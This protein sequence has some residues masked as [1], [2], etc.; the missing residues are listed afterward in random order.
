MLV[1]LFVHPSRHSLPLVLLF[2]F[3][4][5]LCFAPVAQAASSVALVIASRGEVVAVNDQGR[6]VLQRRSGLFEGDRIETGNN[7]QVQIRFIDGALLT[8]EHQTKLEISRFENSTANKS[9]Q[10]L[11]RLIQGGLRNLTG[12]IAEQHPE[13]Y[14]VESAIA[15]IGVRGT[16]FRVVLR[17]DKLAAGV[18]SGGIVVSNDAG[19]L[20][21]GAD[22][23]FSFAWV[24]SPRLPPTGHLTAPLLLDDDSPQLNLLPPR[25]DVAQAI[26]RFNH[27]STLDKLEQQVIRDDDDT[28]NNPPPVSKLPDWV[29]STPLDQRSLISF[30]GIN[31]QGDATRGTIS[32][33]QSNNQSGLQS[34]P[35]AGLVFE[36]SNSGSTSTIDQAFILNGSNVEMT[37]VDS[38]PI[39]WGKWNGSPELLLYQSQATEPVTEIS[40]N[41]HELAWIYIQDP[42]VNLDSFSSQGITRLNFNARLD[43]DNNWPLT[44]VGSKGSLAT[45]EN[46]MSL[47]INLDDQTVDVQFN[48]YSNDLTSAWTRERT[49]PALAFT[50]NAGIIGFSGD[51]TLQHLSNNNTAPASLAANFSF[52]GALVNNP[53]SSVDRQL[54]LPAVMQLETNDQSHWSQVLMI[55]EGSVPNT[56]GG[57]GPAGP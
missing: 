48:L 42:L 34:T 29:G 14:R 23:E 5:A 44:S 27:E 13:R 55:L 30:S 11:L 35:P 9:G 33:A 46:Q 56:S 4:L 40:S 37:Q 53:T 38:L 31:A 2:G 45:N 32:A 43:V 50:N 54:L 39:Y 16:D 12:A 20:E 52:N 10:V 47:G 6:R 7:S 41:N 3:V 57:T 51:A 26:V 24:T 25:D 15:S 36:F 8:L 21:L 17:N 1:M 19:L 22:R 18:Y 28:P 49:A